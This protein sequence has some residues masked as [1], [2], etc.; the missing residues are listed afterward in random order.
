M[1][2]TMAKN[3]IIKALKIRKERGEDPASV[4]ETWPNLTVAEKKTIKAEF[5]SQKSR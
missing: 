2:N 5:D 1:L 3:I 4:L